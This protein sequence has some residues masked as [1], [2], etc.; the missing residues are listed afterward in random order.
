MTLLMNNQCY[1]KYSN[2]TLKIVYSKLVMLLT[3]MCSIHISLAKSIGPCFCEW[4]VA[5]TW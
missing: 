5:E 4:F 2:Q 3:L 1:T